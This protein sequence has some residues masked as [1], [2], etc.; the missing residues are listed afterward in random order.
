MKELAKKISR[1]ICGDNYKKIPQKITFLIK[2]KYHEKFLFKVASKESVFTSIWKNNYWGNA[3]SISGPGSTLGQTEN[4]RKELP[5]LIQEFKIFSV[6]DAPCGDFNWMKEVVAQSNIDYIGGDIVKGIIE[7][8][9]SYNNSNTKFL[10]FDITSDKFPQSDLWICRDVLFHLSYLDILNALK[11][12]ASSNIPYFLT[13]IHKNN[14]KFNNKNINTGDFRQIDLFAEPF[15]FEPSAVLYRFND[16]V[17]PQLPREM[18]LFP[19]E[20]IV[21]V[22]AKF[23]K[24]ISQL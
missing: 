11:Q 10:V 19:R 4:I 9:L 1:N 5:I 18:C 21:E 24:K 3:E 2:R 23:E 7:Q 13:T 22:I 14:N 20:H 12:Y 16:Y 6:F 8:N 17:E 15:C